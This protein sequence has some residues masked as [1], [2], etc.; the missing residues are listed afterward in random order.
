MV[1]LVI[2]VGD[3]DLEFA[4]AAAEGGKRVVVEGLPRKAQHAALA[5]RA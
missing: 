3:V 1:R 5:E 2:G 4:E